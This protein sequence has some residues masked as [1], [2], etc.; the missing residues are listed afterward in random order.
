MWLP[1]SAS[2]QT[3]D[4]CC[5]AVGKCRLSNGRKTTYLTD[6]QLWALYPRNKLQLQLV[7]FW[8]GPRFYPSLSRL[9]LQPRHVFSLLKK[10]VRAE[11]KDRQ[12]TLKHFEH[13]RMV[14]PKKA[15]QI[16]P[17]VSSLCSPPF[18]RKSEASGVRSPD[19]CATVCL[20]CETEKAQCMVALYE[21]VWMEK[22]KSFMNSFHLSS[23]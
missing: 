17:Q 5:Q 1:H 9:S 20:L 11:Q 13:V 18:R 8:S 6:E 22:K 2:H 10:Y 19:G 15:A 21:C 16:R 7:A 4:T 14:D 3:Q 23:I 12:H